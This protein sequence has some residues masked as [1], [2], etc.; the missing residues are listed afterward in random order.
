MKKLKSHSSFKAVSLN[1]N[2]MSIVIQQTRFDFEPG[3]QRIQLNK[4]VKELVIPLTEVS[5]EELEKIR[6]STVPSFILKKDERYYYCKITD[7]LSFAPSFVG[8]KHHKCFS[9]KMCRHL[10]A[11]PDQEG[12]CAKVRNKAHFIERYPWITMGYE[13]INCARCDDTFFVGNCNHF[14]ECPPRK[15]KAP[16]IGE[17]I[18]TLKAIYDLLSNNQR[19]IEKAHTKNCYHIERKF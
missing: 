6:Q 5:K 1:L 16:N 18:D 7:E 2:P 14:E 9:K 17:H 10:S 12:G 13:T 11:A 4:E 15:W 3:K 19:S 8:Q